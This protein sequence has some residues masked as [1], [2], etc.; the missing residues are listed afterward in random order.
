MFG[1]RRRLEAGLQAFFARCARRG[2]L[3][4]AGPVLVIAPHP[5]D[6][7]LGCGATIARLRAAGHRVRI[8]I[9]TD[10]AASV[11]SGT[12]SPVYLAARRRCEAEAAG[13]ILGVAREDLICL[14]FP[15][16]GAGGCVAAI[17]NALAAQIKALDPICVFAPYGSDDHPDHRAVAA[18]VDRLWQAGGINCPV[19]EYPIWFWSRAAFGHL[20]KPAALGRLKRVA[21]QPFLPAKKAAIAAHRSQHE[22]PVGEPGWFRLPPEFLERFL[23]PYELFFEKPRPR[24]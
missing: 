21:T 1:L 19:Y 12:V 23:G 4:P 10:G 2:E 9:V 15:D 18:A 11:R 7:S 20:L 3:S 17:A 14:A 22:A 16:G 6:E 5:D 24:G 13:R 8:V